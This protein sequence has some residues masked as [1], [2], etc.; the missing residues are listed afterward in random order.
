MS[1]WEDFCEAN[2]WNVGSA[3]DYEKFLD[4]LED[5]HRRRTQSNYQPEDLTGDHYFSTFLEASDWAKSNPGKPISR[6]PDGNGYIARREVNAMSDTLQARLDKFDKEVQ[7]WHKTLDKPL[8][9][10]DYY[11][12]PNAEIQLPK[13]KPIRLK[14]VSV[15]KGVE[16]KLRENYEVTSKHEWFETIWGISKYK[17]YNISACTIKSVGISHAGKCWA[18]SKGEHGQD[19]VYLI[20]HP[21]RF[22]IIPTEQGFDG[23]RSN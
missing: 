21:E 5:R 3:D 8:E 15:P 20:E 23:R 11:D 2:G 10:S 6:S 12:C 1:D 4:S 19:L 16:L 18:V 14:S 9:K 13:A 22:F 7:D 17:K